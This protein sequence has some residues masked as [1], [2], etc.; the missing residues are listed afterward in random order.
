[1]LHALRNRV[2][3][4]LSAFVDGFQAAQRLRD[5]SPTMFNTLTSTPVHFHYKND[6]HYH[7]K[8]HPTI[9]MEQ[10]EIRQIN[11]SPPFQAPLMPNTPMEFYDALARFDELLNDESAIFKRR[12]NEGDAVIFDNRRVLHARTAYEEI[13]GDALTEASRWLKGCYLEGDAVWDRYRML[14]GQ[15]KC[16]DSNS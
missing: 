3:G 2:K 7:Y 4:G 15:L 1:M 5:I 10:D 13:P 16:L 12:M 14:K 6:G 8:C 9:E 11:Y